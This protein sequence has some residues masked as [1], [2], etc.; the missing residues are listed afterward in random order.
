[1][2]RGVYEINDTPVGGGRAGLH[3]QRKWKQPT[4]NGS[5]LQKKNRKRTNRKR[6]EKEQKKNRKRT[7]KEQKKNRK[8]TE[9][10]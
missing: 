10:E 9:K 4:K 7:E 8:R 6:T 2:H 3:S 1:V 5:S